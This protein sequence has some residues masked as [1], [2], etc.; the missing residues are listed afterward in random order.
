MR[1]K[2][3]VHIPNTAEDPEFAEGSVI[4]MGEPR[5]TLTVPLTRD[6]EVIGG[7]TLRQSH[8]TPFTARQIE[9]IETF[10]DQAVIAIANVGLFEQVQER[11][12]DL[13]ESLQQQTATADVLKIISRSSVDLETV[14]DRLVET[15][16]LLC[17]ADQAVMFRRRVINIIWS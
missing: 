12:N 16:A 14:L 17:R 11:T 6:G 2:R 13:S 5:A 7:I 3:T 10:A 4:G 1:E 9:A 8:L 15:V